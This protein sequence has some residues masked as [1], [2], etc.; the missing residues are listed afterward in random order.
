MRGGEMFESL[1]ECSAGSVECVVEGV[2][3]RSFIS[4]SGM[5]DGDRVGVYVVFPDGKFLAATL[6]CSIA[7]SR[8]FEVLKEK[9]RLG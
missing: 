6:R 9:T 3:L 1:E 8:S 2:S 4:P 5:G 7:A